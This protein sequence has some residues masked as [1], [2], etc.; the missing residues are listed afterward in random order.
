MRRFDRGPRN[1]M[2]A[3]LGDQA[4]YLSTAGRGPSALPAAR[5][6]PLHGHADARRRGF[7]RY[8]LPAS[9]SRP[10][11]DHAE[12]LRALGSWR[13]PSSCRDSRRHSPSWAART[14][15]A[16]RW[17]PRVWGT[18]PA[19]LATEQAPTGGAAGQPG[20]GVVSRPASGD[21]QPPIAAPAAVLPVGRLGDHP[22][23]HQGSPVIV[24]MPLPSMKPGIDVMG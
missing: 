11:F 6:S 19:S 10:S 23:C 13:R 17:R 21:V 20:V 3:A 15:L 4:L 9:E 7:N 8:G 22:A 2:E 14:T 5:S 16:R 24:E 1:A 18:G 12:R